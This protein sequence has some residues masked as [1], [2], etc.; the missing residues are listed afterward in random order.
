MDEDKVKIYFNP[1]VYTIEENNEFIR[2]G[3]EP[4][5][6]RIPDSKVDYRKCEEW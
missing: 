4:I 2:L 1:W 5:P 6:M 3:Y